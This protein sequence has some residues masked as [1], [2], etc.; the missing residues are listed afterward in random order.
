M[1]QTKSQVV[2]AFRRAE[3][4]EAARRVF[5][6]R[7]YATASVDEIAR[8]ASVAKGTVYLYYPSKQAIYWA[9]LRNGL[10]EL[11]SQLRER[12]EREATLNGKIRAFVATKV[13]YLSRHRDFFRIYQAE[14][15]RVALSG[16]CLQKDLRG[17]YQEQL[18]LLRSAIEAG[19]KR[20]EIRKL[21]PELAAL[22]IV[23]VTRGL[24]TEKL[25]ASPASAVDVDA[26]VELLWKGLAGR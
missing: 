12:T 1:V 9:A 13:E 17:L 8:A 15:G 19:V 23:A 20:R 21:R 4:L 16:G 2:A 24:I 25:L 5:G 3:I 10:T 18:E 26:V 6:Q 7:G 22:G 14:F 11:R